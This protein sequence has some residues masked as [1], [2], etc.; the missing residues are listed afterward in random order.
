M[1][2]SGD[3]GVAQLKKSVKMGH[4]TRQ[5]ITNCLGFLKCGH[6]GDENEDDYGRNDDCDNDDRD[7]NCDEADYGGV[8]YDRNK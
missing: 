1:S 6:D 7:D 3:K 4:P 8:D 2:L 5:A